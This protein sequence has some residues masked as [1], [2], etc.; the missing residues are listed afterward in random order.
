MVP[1]ASESVGELC[2][3]LG[4]AAADDDSIELPVF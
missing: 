2:P 3:M 4:D 1:T